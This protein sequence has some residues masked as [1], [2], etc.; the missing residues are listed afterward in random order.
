MLTD[1]FGRTVQKEWKDIQKI[2]FDQSLS[3]FWGFIWL[4]I[5]I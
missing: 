2:Q 3:V 4:C 5:Y 1:Y